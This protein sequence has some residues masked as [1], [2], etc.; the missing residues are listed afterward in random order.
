MSFRRLPTCVCSFL[1]LATL[2]AGQSRSVAIPGHVHRSAQPQYDQGRVADSFPLNDLTLLLKPSAAQQTALEELLAAQ[3]DPASPSYRQW[4]SPAE[5]ADRFS[6]SQSDLDQV[7]AWLG[8][9]GFTVTHV[10]QS[11]NWIVFRGTAQQAENALSTEIH[12]YVV[13][14]EQHFANASEP[15]IPEAF[16]GL[17]SGFRGLHDFLPRAPRPK[18]APLYTA[19]SN[20]Y[21]APDDIAAVYN[22]TALFNQGI[23]GTGQ[24]IAIVGQTALNVADIQ[25][26]R[27]I[28]HLPSKTPQVVT[29]PGKERLRIVTDQLLE[30]DLDLEWAGA[31]AKNAAL[32]Y[33]GAPNVFDAVQYAVSQKLA[34][35]ISMSYG[36]CETGNQVTAIQ[37]RA[38]AQQANAEGITWLNASGDS[39]AAC[40]VGPMATQGLAVDL[41]ASIP[42]VTGVGGT[43]FNDSGSGYWSSSN[44]ANGGSATGYIP[45]TAWND[46][47][48]AGQVEATSQMEATGGGASIFFTKP[49]WQTGPGVPASNVRYVPDVAMPASAQHD[50]ALVCTGGECA[51][52]LGGSSVVVGGTSLAAPIFAGIVALVNQMQGTLDWET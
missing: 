39:G 1:F 28:F 8:A 22:L 3:Q 34:P 37:L 52:G 43:A 38:L 23:D 49:S 11:R 31:A 33:V 15:R 40:E 44:G 9:Q 2:A 51:N 36:S 30:A 42:E 46:T 25:N 6:P 32:I 19:G 50:G 20:H 12:R 47:A 17:I 13:G 7:T 4:L 29:V 45:E 24:T 41:P 10:G 48:K 18:L 26:F 35:V 27:S 21:L 5:F 16:A 14:G